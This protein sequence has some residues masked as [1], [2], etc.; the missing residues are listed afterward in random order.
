MTETIDEIISITKDEDWFFPFEWA[1]AQMRAWKRVY[2]KLWNWKWMCVWL[3]RWWWEFLDYLVMD[4]WEYKEK[5][6][7][8]RQPSQ[9]DLIRW[10]RQIK[11]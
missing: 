8:P 1:L 7:V 4:L 2:N 9:L 5:R 3:V 11:E 6:F 10:L